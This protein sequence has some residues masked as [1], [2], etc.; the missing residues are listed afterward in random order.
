M[1]RGMIVSGMT[2][3]VPEDQRADF[4][5]VLHN[6]AGLKKLVGYKETEDAYI[7]VLDRSGKI[8]YQAHRPTP[9]PGYTQLHAEVESLLK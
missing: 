6:E 9:E 8:A 7:V 5:P 3:G 4:I 2:R 1:I